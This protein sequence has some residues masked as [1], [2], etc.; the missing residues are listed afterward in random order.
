MHRMVRGLLVQ[1]LVGLSC[2]ETD[3]EVAVK[4]LRAL[5]LAG[6][7]PVVVVGLG[8]PVLADAQTTASGRT[9]TW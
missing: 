4:T 7:L 2:R 1:I 3:S 9:L 6:L 5:A 8:L